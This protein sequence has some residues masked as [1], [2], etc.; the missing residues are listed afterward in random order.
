MSNRSKWILGLTIV[1]AIVSIWEL[2][3]TFKLM[4]KSDEEIQILRNEDPEALTAL[5]KESINLGLDLKGGMHL[6]LEVDKEKLPPEQADDARQRVL[7]IIRNR[8]DEFG[9]AEPVI[10]PQG[11]DRILIQLPG[12]SDQERAKEIIRQTALLEFRLVEEPEETKFVLDRIDMLLRDRLLLEKG[13]EPLEEDI[14]EPAREA[15]DASETGVSEES[16]GESP[17]QGAGSDAEGSAADSMVEAEDAEKDELEELF[18]GSE[19]E[20]PVPGYE[21][22]DEQPFTSL[23]GFY[24][25]DFVIPEN[26]LSQIEKY[27]A[28]PEVKA[29]VPEG[30]ELALGMKLQTVK[31]ENA[32]FRRYRTLMLLE[33]NAEFMGSNLTD[34]RTSS[35]YQTIE[36]IVLLSFER[37]M[38]RKFA[39]FTG[40]HLGRRLAI[41]LDGKIH[42]APVLR[43]RIPDGSAQIEGSY[44]WEEATDLAICLRSGS[45]PAPINIVEERTVGPTL[46]ADSIKAGTYSALFGLIVV[47]MFMIFY[48]KFSGIIANLALFLNL[49]F[50]L[51]LLSMFH[52]TLTLPGIAGIILTIGMAV[53]A[54]VLVFSRIRE[55]AR[56]GKTVK[57]T[58]DSGFSRA[59]TTILDANITTLLTAMF[60]YYFGTGPIRGFAVTLSL[61]IICSL[62]TAILVSRLIFE[63]VYFGGKFK[64]ISI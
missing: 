29:L 43:S 15:A 37:K 38:V 26:N 14:E 1:L 8:V 16:A 2:V 27:L 17:D 36:P 52:A 62:Y 40:E 32:P 59:V 4:A 21:S 46:G 31:V 41:V 12:I 49:F 22:S 57:A 7:E 28:D 35:N 56:T 53:D 34:A 24:G 5:E 45:L 48:F 60:L 9:V 55:E 61:G 30:L 33:K 63:S 19:E 54:N 51:A 6:V 10:Q 50:V 23:L 42:T 58:I 11:E 3:P 13:V 39:D 20:T 47:L 64:K 25:S 44:S 18:I